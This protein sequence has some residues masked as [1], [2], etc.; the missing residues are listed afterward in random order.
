[1][2]SY[3]LRSSYYSITAVWS[4]GFGWR[5]RDARLLGAEARA[6]VQIARVGSE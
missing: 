4:V 5:G 3:I 2:R 1:M 6:N